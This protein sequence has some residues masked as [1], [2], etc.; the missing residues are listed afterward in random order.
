MLGKDRDDSG[1][2]LFPPVAKVNRQNLQFIMFRLM[3]ASAAI[4][5]LLSCTRKPVYPE[6][7]SRG[8][9]VAVDLKTLPDRQPVHFTLHCDG[10]GV[11]FFVFRIGDSV[12]SYFDA[13]ARCYPQKL[14]YR[15]DA[16]GIS[17]RACN[18]KYSLENLKTGAGSCYPI[19][20]PGRVEK[21]FYLISIRDLRAGARYF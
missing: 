10:K 2:E 8:D 17:C 20:L 13:C 16:G 3:A 7:V 11:N 14:G 19:E 21:L 18:L 5:F 6:A 15:R 4:L 1:N 9:A 12:S